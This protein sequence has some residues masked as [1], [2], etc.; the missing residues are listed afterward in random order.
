MVADRRNLCKGI[1]RLVLS[2]EDEYVGFIITLKFC[3]CLKLCKKVFL[4]I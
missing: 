2:P 3:I 4:K 1:V